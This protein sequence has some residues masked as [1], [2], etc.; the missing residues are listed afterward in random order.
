[1]ILQAKIIEG[2]GLIEQIFF[3]L[4]KDCC[5]LELLRRKK[6]MM[7]KAQENEQICQSITSPRLFVKIVNANR[8][9]LNVERG[10]NKFT[11]PTF[12]LRRKWKMSII[13]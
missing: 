3:S 6:V 10:T 5:T 2:A 13:I 1:M 9:R 11:Q 8:V 12:N 7:N 4:R